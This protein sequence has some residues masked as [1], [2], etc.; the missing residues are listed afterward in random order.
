MIVSRGAAPPTVRRSA[1]TIQHSLTRGAAA[2]LGAIRPE[3]SRAIDEGL[4]FNSPR[5]TMTGMLTGQIARGRI[6]RVRRT[7]RVN[8]QGLIA[9]RAQ[10]RSGHCGQRL[11]HGEGGG[12]LFMSVE[13][14]G[15]QC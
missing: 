11:I 3:P 4:L 7:A 15:H 14:A 2:K 1:V 13:G 5:F 8:G 12:E 10:C 9:G 6:V